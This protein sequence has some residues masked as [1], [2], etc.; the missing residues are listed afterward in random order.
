[1]KVSYSWSNEGDLQTLTHDLVGTANDVAFTDH[2]TPAHQISDSTLSNPAFRFVPA[3]VG[4]DAYAAV[5]ALNQYPTVT[6]AG[7][8]A[9]AIGYDPNGNL[10]SDG[11]FAFAYDP[12]NRLM[13]AAKTGTS[14]AY[15][16]D[17]LGRR[18][19]KSVTGGSYAGTTYFLD[20]GDDEI[21]EYDNTGAL[22]RRFVPGDSIDQP[23][24]MVTA[25]GVK[26][27]FHQDKTGSVIAMSDASGAIT[28]GPYTYDAYGNGAPYSGVP[29]KYTGRRLD[30]ET[31]LYYYRARYYSSALGRFLQTDPI[32]YKDDLDAYLY[33]HDDPTDKT[34]PTGLKCVGTGEKSQCT[35]DTYDGKKV[36]AEMREKNP[37][38]TKLEARI[39]EGYKELQ[40]AAAKG[41]TIHIAGNEK[42]GIKDID[43]SAKN[44]LQ[45]ATMDEL[46]GVSS[47]ITRTDPISGKTYRPMI[48]TARNVMRSTYYRNAFRKNLGHVTEGTLHD[49]L[50]LD[51]RTQP[52]DGHPLEHQKPFN[53]AANSIGDS[54]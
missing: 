52:W 45:R 42:L 38:I 21:A 33:V 34:D 2:Y 16:Y 43:I 24:A 48:E 25:A 20:S 11:T 12:E 8:S 29:Y 32:G 22:Q 44:L 53:D 9:T 15:A 40:V 28:E 18:T 54:Q 30:P 31:G 17:P 41:L 27:F 49:W 23:I 37:Q 3:V 1:M 4:T 7:G 46:V 35:L 14:V 6:P 39:T 5:N 19:T 10:T 51:P 36:T 50:H 26:T 47:N 13:T